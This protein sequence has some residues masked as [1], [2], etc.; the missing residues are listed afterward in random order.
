MIGAWTGPRD[1]V[2]AILDAWRTERPGLDFSP[3]AIF[4]RITRIERYEAAALRDVYH[5]HQVDSGEYRVLAA[6]R[7]SGPDYRLTPPSST[8]ACWSA[9]P[10]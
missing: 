1:H 2:A 3:T 10:P 8:A 9:R 7:R 5:R 4:G 6:L